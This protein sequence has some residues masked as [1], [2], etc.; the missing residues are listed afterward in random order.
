MENSEFKPSCVKDHLYSET[1][2]LSIKI[3]GLSPNSACTI[4][5]DFDFC[6]ES[7]DR[8]LYIKSIFYSL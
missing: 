4:D 5:R 8:S 6:K 2:H 7:L 3:T 1:M